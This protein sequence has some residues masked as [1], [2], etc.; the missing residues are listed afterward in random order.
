MLYLDSSALVKLVIWEEGS[1]ALTELLPQFSSPVSSALASVE[2]QRTIRR[3]TPDAAV[4]ARAQQVLAGV[5]LL[6]LD[7][8]VLRVAAELRPEI[9]RSLDALHLATAL[10]IGED[11]EALITYDDR[12]ATAASENGLRVLAPR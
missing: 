2:V 3:A 12:L 9:L 10:S 11:L 8:P 5:I 7:D 1:D 4:L 6:K